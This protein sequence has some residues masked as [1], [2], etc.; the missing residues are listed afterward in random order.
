[1]RKQIEDS[2]DK[3]NN[4]PRNGENAASNGA[5]GLTIRSDKSVVD[6]GKDLVV[7]VF[8]SGY[9]EISGS[10]LTYH[11][12]SS[13]IF[14][15]C[16]IHHSLKQEG[17]KMM[18]GGITT[19]LSNFG[20]TIILDGGMLQEG[21]QRPTLFF[22]DPPD[23]LDVA[24][25]RIATESIHNSYPP[26]R[27]DLQLDKNAAPGIYQLQFVLAYFNGHEWKISQREIDLTI[28]SLFQRYQGLAA[29]IAALAAASAIAGAIASVITAASGN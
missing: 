24:T 26:F 10:K 11:P 27:M 17:E 18:W 12:S 23:E 3:A 28:R 14:E 20:G 29:L 2:K 21:W 19:R 8:I 5:Y 1:M 15:S 16:V 25:P 6:P 13:S 4:Q 7:G 9:G 22:D